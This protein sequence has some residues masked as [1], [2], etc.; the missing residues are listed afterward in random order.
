MPDRAGYASF[1]VA[2]AALF[3][4]ALVAALLLWLGGYDP[5]RAAEAMWSGAF[6]SR[7][8][9][10]SITLVRSAPLMLTGLAVALA[11][12]AGVWNIG[13]EGQLYAGAIAAVWVGLEGGTMPAWI[14]LPAVLVAAGT[15][16]ALWALVPALMKLRLG[17]GEVIT[18]ILMNFVAIHLAAYLVH[19]PLQE[20]RG[21][22]PQTGAIVEAARLP[23]LIPGTRLHM[24][25]AL[26]VVLA[27]TLAAFLR[28]TRLGFRV[29]AVGASS[30]AAWVAGRI[31]ASA[32]V[33]ATFLA[34]GALAGLAG[35]VEITGLTY[36]LYEGLSPGWGYTAIAV[37]L[38]AALNP[39]AVVGTAVLFGALEAGSGAMQRE[40][41]IPAVW[42]IAVEA[43]VILAVL[44]TDQVWRRHLSR[45]RRKPT[46]DSDGDPA[47]QPEPARA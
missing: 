17:V 37:A 23:T 24:G 44:A 19:G 41:G 30:R 21:V 3:V 46:G 35:G 34:S 29:R 33:L 22:F 8:Q 4:T 18:T 2:A 1:A 20:P 5:L 10:L 13:A 39:V 28:W 7:D 32:V 25:F 12:K 6:G 40:A 14:L 43:L 16:G 36:A 45:A 11:F 31:D 26:A 42:V 47:S 9:I 15:A 27:V 38:L